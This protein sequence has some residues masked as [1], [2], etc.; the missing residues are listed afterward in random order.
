MARRHVPP[1]SGAQAGGSVAISRGALPEQL[2][3]ACTPATVA[4]A[5]ACER[6]NAR[7]PGMRQ[8]GPLNP[9]FAVDSHL[10]QT[11]A[12][13]RWPPRMLP[14]SGWR[15]RAARL[16]ALA[17]LVGLLGYA[18][19]LAAGASV[20]RDADSSSSSAAPLHAGGAASSGAA[21]PRVRAA[22][23]PAPAAAVPMAAPV[24]EQALADA[25]WVRHARGLRASKAPFPA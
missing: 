10:D 7:L 21:Q 20:P 12:A 23:G 5:R 6:A 19:A 13:A 4:A 14:A 16:A 3:A 22:A 24:S 17:A 15:P 2:R 9:Q 25:L 1:Q 8:T 18:A 11:L